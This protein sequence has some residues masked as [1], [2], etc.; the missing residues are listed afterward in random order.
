ME[1]PSPNLASICYDLHKLWLMR[2][3]FNCSFSHTI[4]DGLTTGKHYRAGNTIHVFLWSRRYQ[5][6]NNLKSIN[7]GL[8]T[9][10]A[11]GGDSAHQTWSSML[12]TASN[13]QQ[14]INSSITYLRSRNFDG[15]DLDFEYP[16]KDASPPSDKQRFTALV[17]VWGRLSRLITSHQH[18]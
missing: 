6:F 14:F 3:W 10:L 18:R 15:L 2:G 11:V 8:K 4:T 5:Q 16:G 17:Q 12:S 13:R 9:L 7:P 1:L